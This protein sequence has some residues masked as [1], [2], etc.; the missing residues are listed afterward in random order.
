MV[1]NK[2]RKPVF[3]KWKWNH[4]V[5]S[6]ATILL[7]HLINMMVLLKAI[8][9]FLPRFWVL[10]EEGYISICG[11]FCTIRHC[12][13]TNHDTSNNTSPNCNASS[14]SL[15]SQVLMTI[16]SICSTHQS[17]QLL[18]DFHLWTKLL[19]NQP[20]CSLCPFKTHLY[21]Y[22]CQLRL[23]LL[24]LLMSQP[25]QKMRV[26]TS[27]MLLKSAPL[28]RP[29]LFIISYFICDNEHWETTLKWPLLAPLYNFIRSLFTAWWYLVIILDISRVALSLQ[30]SD[31]IISFSEKGQITFAT[32]N[33]T[34]IMTLVYSLE[35]FNNHVNIANGHHLF[36]VV[37]NNIVFIQLMHLPIPIMLWKFH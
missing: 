15:V 10:F 16:S 33:Y 1:C 32:H 19:R 36:P 29:W 2:K 24:V 37:Q 9:C 34:V 8:L 28:V 18:H 20:S 31:V 4:V 30:S 5:F 3:I 25:F 22:F 27:P 23:F 12:P 14:S 6:K 35:H 11:Y 26:S 7:F 17:Y 13:S 21:V